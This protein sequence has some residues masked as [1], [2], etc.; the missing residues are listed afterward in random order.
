M[1]SVPVVKIKANNSLG[2][3]IINE[4]DFDSKKHE[5]FNI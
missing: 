1:A 4:S 5:L 2:Y 3:L